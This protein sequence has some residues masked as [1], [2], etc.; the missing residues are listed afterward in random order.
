MESIHS[1]S[2]PTVHPT[3]P[4]RILSSFGA[5]DVGFAREHNEDAFVSD[6]DRGIFLVSDGMGGHAGGE[7][8]SALAISESHKLLQRG[9]HGDPRRTLASVFKATDRAVIAHAVARPELRGMGCTLLAAV[10]HQ[11]TM[12]IAH[13]GDSRAYLWRNGL[14]KPLTHDQHNGPYIANAI[15]M[16]ELSPEIVPVDPM[17]GDV[18]ILCTDGLTNAVHNRVIAH[19]LRRETRCDAICSALIGAALRAGGPDNVTV[20]V[21]SF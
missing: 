7:V 2:V 11:S 17:R 10:Q 12:W 16:L 13:A 4:A 18:L 3:S 21:V 19:H 20:V 5:T 14:L 1:S 15:G 8:A 6:P 9:F